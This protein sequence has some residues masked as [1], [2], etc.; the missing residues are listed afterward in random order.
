[1]RTASLFAVAALL[2]TAAPAFA[3]S[4][5]LCRPTISPADGPQLW[6]LLG[7]IPGSGIFQATLEQ[8]NRS[9]TTGQGQA[10][11]RVGQSWLDRQSLRVSIIDANAEREIARLE[12]WRRAGSSYL[13][14]L[15]YGGRTWRVR[16]SEEG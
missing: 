13:G 5:M 12:A 1:M 10:A 8:G 15:H 14:T 2:C 11:P 6:L 16:C 9:F 7:P 4:S 3:S